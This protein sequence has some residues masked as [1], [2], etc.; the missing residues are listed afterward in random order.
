PLRR[1]RRQAAGDGRGEDRA[2]ARRRKAMTETVQPGR[3][4]KPGKREQD[5]SLTTASLAGAKPEAQQRPAEDRPAAASAA[6]PGTE[7]AEPEG[8]TAPLFSSN[9]TSEFRG[10]WDA[11]QAGF[12]D[13]PRKAV[14]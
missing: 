10:C 5:E 6:A 9:E 12:V 13:E 4:Q 14:E 8:R 3:E 2:P 11:I 1:A 7:A